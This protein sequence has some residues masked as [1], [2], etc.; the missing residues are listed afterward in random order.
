MGLLAC[1][2]VAD[3]DRIWAQYD[4]KP[5]YELLRQPETGLV[6]VSA[7]A[8]GAGQRFN[9][10]EMTMTRCSVGVEGGAVGH[11]FVA[12]RNGRHAELAAVFDALLQTGEHR[13]RLQQLLLTPLESKRRN[14]ALKAA[15]ATR[16]T[17]VEFF[18]MTRGEDDNSDEEDK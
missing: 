2:E 9:M 7:R 15:A 6:M 3:L 17:K 8:G 11:G 13:A 4:A 12:G 18:T 1:A 14:A 10:G 16:E 5:G